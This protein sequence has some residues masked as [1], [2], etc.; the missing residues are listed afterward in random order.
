MRHALPRFPHRRRLRQIASA[1]ARH[2]LGY[3]AGPAGLG[4]LAPFQRG[5]LGHERRDSPYTRPEHV[6]LAL[7]E[8]GA[9]FVKLGQ[10]LSTRGDLLPPDYQAELARLQDAAPPV[11]AGAVLDTVT[12]ELGCDAGSVFA[13]FD[14]Q[15][16]ASASI[17][18]AHAATLLDGSE[19]VVKVRRPGVVAQVEEDLAILAR[20]AVRAARR[21]ELARRYDLP[22]LVA[23]FSSTLRA[24]LDYLQEGR[25]AE[26]FAANF[27]D[28]PSVHIPAVRWE[29]TTS[30][31]LTLERLRGVKVSDASALD[32]AGLDRAELARSAATISL[33]MVFEHGFFHADPHPG[34]FFVE[35]DGAI[36][37]IDFGMVGAVDEATRQRLTALLAGFAAGDGDALVDNVLSLGVAGASVDR[38][39][40]RGDLLALATEQLNRPLG[41]VSFGSLLGEILVVVRRH[42]LVLPADLAL[43]IKTIAMSEGVGAQIDPSF[44]LAAV[45]L[46]FLAGSR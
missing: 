39:R 27:G 34:N 2:G 16:L 29:A 24:E 1:A 30:Q 19:V 46:P 45:I 44:R 4:R 14:L 42:Q 31:V 26:R 38:A 5:W 3:L 10:I 41:D 11:P 9:T 32:A 15:P 40:L 36:G 28:D 21:S 18:Q 43:L 22:G 12:V 8:Q 13:T 33:R 23:E 35:P 7:E 17:G 6:R 37:L 25:N 20:L